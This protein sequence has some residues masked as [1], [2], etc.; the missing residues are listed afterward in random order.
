MGSWRPFAIGQYRLGQLKGEAVAVWWADGKRCR[1][2]LSVRTEIEGR[3]ALA[4]FARG[5]AI[6]EAASLETIGA[7]WSAY[8]ADRERDGKNM[9]IYHFNWKALQPVFAHLK[10]HEIS[11]DDCRA[12][13]RQRF[14]DGRAASTVHT[15]LIRLRGALQW[16]AK[17][18]I[19]ATAPYVWAPSPSQP[20]Q[21]VLSEVEIADLLDGCIE[22]HVR[23]FVIIAVCTGG[24]HSA[25]LE[26]TWDRIDFEA[27]T[28]DLKAPRRIEPMS[29][30]HQKGRALV[31][32]NNL[33][34]AALSEAREAAIGFHVVEWRG[35]KVASIKGGLRK[36]VVRAGIEGVTAHTLRHTAATMAWNAGID[37][38]RIA[39][40]LGHKDV[41]TTRSTYA[42]P[43]AAFTAP[44]ANVLNLSLVRRKKV[45]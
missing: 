34:R 27:G 11:A 4:R 23:L 37:P 29:Q 24:R 43:D 12:Y 2:R 3:D 16:G 13:A 40:L 32:M 7:I 38:E 41:R 44:A 22:P 28:I 42:H 36:A 9:D 25:I 15:E 21:R 35:Q 5:R 30:R 45:R 20:R 26:L 17:R 10:P 8:V 14:A 33:V 31:A 39:R 19:I 6:T 1:Y 18:R